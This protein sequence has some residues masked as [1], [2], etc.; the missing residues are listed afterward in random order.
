MSSF[1]KRFLWTLAVGALLAGGCVEND[2]VEGGELRGFGDGPVT[3]SGSDG[4]LDVLG[5]NVDLGLDDLPDGMF[6]DAAPGLGTIPFEEMDLPP[7]EPPP[8]V[9]NPP[10]GAGPSAAPPPASTAPPTTAPATTTT[11]A[12]TP[13]AFTVASVRAVGDYCT[14]W[15]QYGNIQSRVGDAVSSGNPQQVQLAFQV[16]AAVY[17]RGGELG[18]GDRRND[19][20]QIASAMTQYDTLLGNFGH[21]FIAML[22]AA[23]SDPAV[24]SQLEAI[25][26]PQ[27]GAAMDRVDAHIFS[28]CGVQLT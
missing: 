28:A 9:E 15:R 4:D 23:E 7:D 13:G 16:A 8:P 27:V 12:I 6:D 14:L 17:T 18:P 19:F 3:P 5:D 25:E 1:A 24:G 26:N 11:V 21:N 10:P 2:V 20:N 22:E